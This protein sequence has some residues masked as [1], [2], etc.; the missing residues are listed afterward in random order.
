MGDPPKLVRPDT[1]H[2]PKREKDRHDVCRYE[3]N[4][5]YQLS[6]FVEENNSGKALPSSSSLSSNGA[7]RTKTPVC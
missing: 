7:E 4:P 5:P 3:L 6:S 1:D 2:P